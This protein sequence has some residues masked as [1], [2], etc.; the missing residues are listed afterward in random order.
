MPRRLKIRSSAR[1]VRRRVNPRS[2]GAASATKTIEAAQPERIFSSRRSAISFIAND[3]SR[4]DVLSSSAIAKRRGDPTLRTNLLLQLQKTHGNRAVQRMLQRATLTAHDQA[5]QTTE[6]AGLPQRVHPSTAQNPASNRETAQAASNN[7]VQPFSISD[8]NPIEAAKRLAARAW[9]AIKDLGS[10]AWDAAKNVGSQTWNTVKNGAGVARGA[11][12]QTASSIWNAVKS[13]G[14]SVWNTAQSLGSRAWNFVRQA[15]SRAWDWAKNMGLRVWNGA[16][17]LGSRAWHWAKSFGSNIWN[18]AKSIGSGLWNTVKSLGSRAWS[19]IQNGIGKA[20]NG[21]KALG[22]RIWKSVKSAA[23]KAW[24]L[25]KT[26]GF[27]AWNLGKSIA[28]KLS[29]DNLC[30]AIAWVGK[31]IYDFLAPY[32]RKAWDAVKKIGAKVWEFAKKWAGKLWDTVK[33]WVAKIGAAAKRAL[34]AAYAKVKDLAG[35]AW[36]TAKHLGSRLLNGAK[37]LGARAWNF[38]KSVGAKAWN[39]AKALAGK[40]WNLAKRWGN[41]A[42]E[43]AKRLGAASWEKAKALGTRI[44]DAAKSAASRLLGLADRLT[45]GLASRVAG[46]ANRILSR[47]AGLL[48][49]VLNKA[50]ELADRALKTAKQWASKALE[51]AKSWGQKLWDAANDVASR[52]WDTAKSWASRAW[53]TAKSWAAKAWDAAKTF[54]RKA[55][56]TAKSWAS[57]AWNAAKNLASRAWNTAKSWASKA[58]TTIKSWAGEAWDT[59]KTWA[60]RLWDGVKWFGGK[61]WAAAK[62]VGGKAIALAKSLGLDK[63]W[64]WIKAKGSEVLGWAAKTW[65]GLKKRLGPVIDVVKK[66]G[67]YV[68]KAALLLNPATVPLVGVWA[69]CKTLNCLVPKL[70]TKGGTSEKATDLATDLTPIVSTVKDGCGCLTGDNMVTGEQVGGGERAVRCTVAVIDIVSYVG[71]LFSEGGTAVGEQAAKGAIRAWLERLFK[72]GGKEL[73]EA[74][75]KEIIKQ[76]A[77]MGEKELAEALSKMGERELK[78]LAEQ[79]ARSGEK[80]LA[81]KVEKEIAERAGKGSLTSLE[82]SV[83]IGEKEHKLFVRKVGEDFELWMC[84][85]G[86]GA[87]L[88]RCEK[89]LAKLTDKE[90][91]DEVLAVQRRTE[92]L[93]KGLKSGKYAAEEVEKELE[94]MGRRLDR[95]AAKEPGTVAGVVEDEHGTPGTRPGELDPPGTEYKK[96]VPGLS[97]K[98][99]ATDIPSWVDKYPPPRVGENGKDYATRVLNHKYGEGNWNPGPGSEY[100]QIQKWADRHFE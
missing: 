25:A 51:T 73:A 7:A 16:K 10:A 93:E 34:T 8:L 40:V 61:V 33:G 62:W 77:K 54:G 21:I 78:E 72:I 100:S 36:N 15:G 57:K 27:K 87:V 20:W 4:V 39:G 82:Q 60:G 24:E 12:S 28:D 35:K 13:A 59:I 31:K 81:E 86:C 44:W 3:Q 41:K 99:G 98:E 1:L 96:P 19:A 29:L 46:L 53:N 94:R 69:A 76:F 26:W 91:R 45:G 49:W 75:E 9:G 22:S 95:A 2:V 97:G 74:G 6:A 63:A 92:L 58:W 14:T 85:N 23:G 71:A 68:G 43:T 30:A 66:V 37:Q 47:A 50:R 83:R 88:E 18:R 48:S 80:D 79:A 64:N 55:I 89:L 38:A 42:I 90:A 5:A 32:V 11:L 65:A 17:S 70:V 52:A 67:E 56:E 84:S